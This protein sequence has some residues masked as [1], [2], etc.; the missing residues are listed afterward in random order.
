M[1]TEQTSVSPEMRLKLSQHMESAPDPDFW[2]A[3]FCAA[4]D[5]TL[6]DVE[7]SMS[8]ADKVCHKPDEGIDLGQ[9]HAPHSM[10]IQGKEYKGGEFIPGHVAAKMTESEKAEVAAGGGGKPERKL[11]KPD[12]TKAKSLNDTRPKEDLTAKVEEKTLTY[13]ETARQIME[14]LPGA[15]W[16]GGHLTA[17]TDGLSLRYGRK[18]ALA[19]VTA[20]QAFGWGMSL[21]GSM[22]GMPVD[23]AFAT[24][25][26]LVPG[27]ALAE[28]HYR[29]MGK[30]A[31]PKPTPAGE[32]D[33]PAQTATQETGK[34]KPSGAEVRDNA[35]SAETSRAV[36]A[37][38]FPDTKY[39]DAVK[40]VAS[41][42]GAPDDATV[43][44][45][46]AKEDDRED[47]DTDSPPTSSITLS[48]RHPKI[49]N[50]VRRIGVDADGR[51]YIE[52]VF[53]ETKEKKTGFGSAL[54]ANQVDQA[55]EH[56]FAYIKTHAAGKPGDKK[57]NGFYTWALLGYDE[58]L[59][60]FATVH[61]DVAAK[62]A[63][64]F[65]GAQSIR[66]VVTDKQRG[67]RQWWK[68]NG[69]DFSGQFDLTADSASMKMMEAYKAEKAKRATV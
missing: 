51:K 26:G 50:A 13:L 22:T 16:F 58:S 41:V 55:K 69:A 68:E 24:T 67:G 5:E 18:Q 39:E 28:L 2:H 12:Q 59:A 36:L 19:I 60:D 43:F 23:R 7:Q 66:D 4:L 20:A 40:H 14:S 10:T 34:P 21:T 32:V 56:G 33:K 57:L 31:K 48:I 46:E 3:V 27:A 25:L 47:D 17:I 37:K 9:I 49:T 64:I 29:M 35:P 42:V 61:P 45:Y 38:I 53:L 54:F 63:E 1:A 15:K 62:V 65:P 11:G 8:L 52:N 30:P 44:I 6:G